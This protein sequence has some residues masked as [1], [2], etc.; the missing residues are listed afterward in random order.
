M[1]S[2]T[3]PFLQPEDTNAAANLLKW[4]SRNLKRIS[5]VCQQVAADKLFLMVGYKILSI[6]SNIIMI[7]K[8]KVLIA[9][10]G[11]ISLT[12]SEQSQSKVR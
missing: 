7:L 12:L 9:F 4:A 3:Q 2:L 5:I 8:Y 10:G 1:C 6:Y 11:W